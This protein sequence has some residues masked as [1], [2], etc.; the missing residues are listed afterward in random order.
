MYTI[1]TLS[2]RNLE[3]RNQLKLWLTAFSIGIDV[4]SAEFEMLFHKNKNYPLCTLRM[5]A[6]TLE[7]FELQWETSSSKP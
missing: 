6:D 3:Q 5:E 2:D 4:G 1:M 7:R